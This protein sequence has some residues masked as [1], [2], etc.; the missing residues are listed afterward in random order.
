M[1][2]WEISKTQ[3]PQ[4]TPGKL[5]VHPYIAVSREYGSRAGVVAGKLAKGKFL[6]ELTTA[7]ESDTSVADQ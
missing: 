2:N 3:Q 5:A 7:P 1:R 6:Y 4:T